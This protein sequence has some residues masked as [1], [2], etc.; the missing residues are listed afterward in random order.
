MNITLSDFLV[1][2]LL[3]FDLNN[4]SPNPKMRATTVPTVINNVES[5]AKSEMFMYSSQNPEK[6]KI[7]PCL[8]Q[9]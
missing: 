3:K 8:P 6:S 1:I 4:F 9:R 2:L 5:I 7:S